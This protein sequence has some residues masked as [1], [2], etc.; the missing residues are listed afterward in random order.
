MT[1]VQFRHSGPEDAGT[2]LLTKR[3][4]EMLRAVAEGHSLD[5]IARHADLTKWTVGRELRRAG[6]KL[7]AKSLPHAVH[8]AHQKGILS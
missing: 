7:G 2:P 3:E 4:S 6:D 1:A 5:W 8:L